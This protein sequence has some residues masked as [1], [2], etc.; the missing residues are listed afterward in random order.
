MPM[1]ESITAISTQSCSLL[2]SRQGGLDSLPSDMALRTSC[3][4]PRTYA[5]QCNVAK[6]PPMRISHAHLCASVLA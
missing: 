2:L 5:Q 1:P 3:S 6:G 4:I